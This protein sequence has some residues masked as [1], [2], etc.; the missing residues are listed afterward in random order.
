MPLNAIRQFLKL[1]SFSG[2][3]L[4]GA[5]AVA[6]GL[7][8]SPWA[9]LYN[10]FLNVSLEV[11][12]GT[13]FLAKP[14]YLWINEGLMAMFF[15]L[16]GL[17]IKREIQ[18]GELSQP[19][20]IVLPGIAAAGGMLLPALIYVGINWGNPGTLDGWAIP[21]ATD[22]AFALG[23]LALLG[24]RVPV[25]LKLFLMALAIIDDLG[26]I[27]I[28]AIFYSHKLSLFSLVF[29]GIALLVLFGM[30]RLKI[31]RVDV[32][33]SVGIFLWL[34]VLNSGVHATLA[35]VVLA[36]AI[37]LRLKDTDRSPLRELEHGLHPWVA[38]AILPLFA[39]A[40]AGVSLQGSSLGTLFQGIPFGVA[41]GLFAGKQVGV[42]GFSWLAVK[43]GFATLPRRT[44]WL[45][46]YG[47]SMLCGIGFTMSLF[48]S[49]LAFSAPELEQ[50]VRDSRLGILLGSLISAVTG[51][52]ILRYTG[53]KSAKKLNKTTKGLYKSRGK[54]P[55]N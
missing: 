16:I 25:A 36:F 40:N 55:C 24:K 5:A 32:Y 34:F 50:Y 47:V 15:L 54:S 7:A 37:P 6:L 8:N 14:L 26:A 52:L 11:R 17:E 35:G 13:L 31:K 23:V 3:L 28:I 45:Q 22:I 49:S 39:F 19:A 4:V 2:M 42:F 18:E 30:N 10:S 12:L 20:Q 29:A 27:I 46:L 51:Y 41:L 9:Q 53:R 21:T 48:I 1:E 44:T 38:Y 33:I 43:L